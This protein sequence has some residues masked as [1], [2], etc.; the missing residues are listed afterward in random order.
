MFTLR[1]PEH[2]VKGAHV[3]RHWTQSERRVKTRCS[4]LS[5]SQPLGS[6]TSA[7]LAFSKLEEWS[8]LNSKQ[9]VPKHTDYPVRHIS[10]NHAAIASFWSLNSQITTSH[11]VSCLIYGFCSK[12]YMPSCVH[13][14]HHDLLVVYWRSVAEYGIWN[15]TSVI[16]ITT[17]VAVV[18]K[19]I[20]SIII[21]SSASLS[22]Y[23]HHSYRGHH[24]TDTVWSKKRN[25]CA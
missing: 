20:T 8:V 17:I 15:I 24:I 23:C 5:E 12:T 11:S 14:V 21:L 22:S 4:Q 9:N 1:D 13:D 7:N 19:V 2:R 3:E 10:I 16:S 18:V 6:V 25:T